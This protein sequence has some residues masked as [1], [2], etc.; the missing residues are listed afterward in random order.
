[1]SVF[2]SHS[3]EN[4]PEFENVTDA[5]DLR[6]VPFWNPAEIRPGASLREQLRAA[7]ERCGLCIFIA[8]RKSIGSSWCG[9]EL[10]AFWG[11]GKPIIVYLAEAS[12]TDDE[13]PQIVQG[14]VWERR[15]SK[16]A[17]RAKEILAQS[18]SDGSAGQVKRSSSVTQ[19][20]VEQLEKMIAGAV[21]L[22]AA[23]AKDKGS[24]SSFEE[25]GSAARSAAGKVLAGFQASESARNGSCDDWRN[26]ILWVDDRPQNNVYE[27]K[28][29][30]SMGLQ[31]TLAESTDEA[32][33]ILSTNR[34]A[35]I[36]SDMGRKEGPREGYVLL[37]AVRMEDKTTPFFIYAGSGSP[38]N[39][40]EAALRG[41]QG[42]TNFA[43]ELIEMVTRS[44]PRG[45]DLRGPSS[46]EDEAGH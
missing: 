17:E 31:F 19:L 33:Q 44:L 22:A 30:E 37:E 26:R 36:I 35:A 13:L 27:R 6:S 25:V 10:G 5:L 46:N 15:I 41:A 4:L 23:T 38:Q 45:P 3:F 18:T 8:T 21:S 2:I 24:S 7:V 1:M 14:D 12:L 43:E 32:M 40:R 11:A 9:A 28:A 42:C 39:R 16:I 29:M 34:F 20:T